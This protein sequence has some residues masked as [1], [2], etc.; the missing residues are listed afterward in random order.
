MERVEPSPGRQSFVIVLAIKFQALNVLL[1]DFNKF[2]VVLDVLDIEPTLIIGIDAVDYF[3][4]L[5]LEL[6]DLGV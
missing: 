2:D 6:L 1:D 4:V 5:H 3:L